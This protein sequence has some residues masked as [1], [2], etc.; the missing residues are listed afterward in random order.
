MRMIWNAAGF[1]SLGLGALGVVLP[2]LPTVPFLLLAA[3]CFARGSQRFHDWLLSHPRFGPPIH[4]W[5]AHGA[6]S[7]RGKIAA[8]C[9]IAAT[10]SISLILGVATHVL[11]IQAVVLGC[12]LIFIL[13]RPNGSSGPEV[14]VQQRR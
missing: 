8:T 2:L 6:I 7:A 3:F 13:T 11:V 9:A 1:L 4:E 14:D 10:F 12:V 5:R